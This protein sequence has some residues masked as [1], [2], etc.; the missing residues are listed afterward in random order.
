MFAEASRNEQEICV[1][2]DRAKIESFVPESLVRFGERKQWSFGKPPEEIVEEEVLPVAPE[3]LAA[4]HHHGATFFQHQRFLAACRGQGAIEVS[5]EDGARAV[6]L[7][8]AA[9]RSI[10][11]GRVVE[12][13]EVWP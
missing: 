13:S 12:W 3:L 2:G 4:G 10:E 1:V 7:G 11:Q 8:V 9:Q 6:A 5:S